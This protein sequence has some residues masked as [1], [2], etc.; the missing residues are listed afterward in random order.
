MGP[1]GGDYPFF[2][3]DLAWA[4]RLSNLDMKQAFDKGKIFA[5]LK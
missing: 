5:G 1:G 4:L 3:S 2:A